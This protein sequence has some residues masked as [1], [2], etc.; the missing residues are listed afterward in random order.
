MAELT[1]L[2]EFLSMEDLSQMSFGNESLIWLRVEFVHVISLD[3]WGSHMAAS[4]RF[5]AGFTRQALFDRELLV[6]VN[7][8]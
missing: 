7:Q 6:E 4:V 1:N 5:F 2:A 8:K 3:S